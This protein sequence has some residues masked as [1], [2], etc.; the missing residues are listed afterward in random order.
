MNRSEVEAILFRLN[1]AMPRFVD[2]VLEAARAAEWFD[3]PL[4][5][6]SIE[7]AVE[8]FRR[9]KVASDVQPTLR[10]FINAC[11][12]VERDARPALEPPDEA[13]ESPEAR[14]RVLAEM[15]EFSCRR[16]LLSGP[17]DD[18]RATVRTRGGGYVYPETARRLRGGNP[19]DAV[20]QDPAR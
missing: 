9:W 6:V 7:H 14:A 20:P 11:R 4:A 16:R 12:A 3:S 10:Q 19:D 1:A 13:E 15:R 18:E 8:A 5:D 2:P 17:P